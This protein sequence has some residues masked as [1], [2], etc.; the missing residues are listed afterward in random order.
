[1]YKKSKSNRD[2][3]AK[4]VVKKAAPVKVNKAVDLATSYGAGLP[5]LGQANPWLAIANAMGGFAGPSSFLKFDNGQWVAGIEADVVPLG[6]LAIAHAQDAELGW[7]KWEDH[8]PVDREMVKLA[9]GHKPKRRDELDDTDKSFWEVDPKDG[10]PKDPWQ[11][12]ALLPITLYETGEK[13]L[14]EISSKGGLYAF[15]KVMKIYGLRVQAMEDEAPGLL[16]VKLG[17]YKY[18]HKKHPEYGWIWNPTLKEAGWVG[19]DNKIIP[20]TAVD[21]D[22]DD[23]SHED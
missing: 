7:R 2:T 15:G 14:Y 23:Q 4:A 12:T 3:P 18:K 13:F 19:P 20:G 21:D 11:A 17:A 22:E 1:M 10:K 5:A 6:T 16:L 8:F 9:N